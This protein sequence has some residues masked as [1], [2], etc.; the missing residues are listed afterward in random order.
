MVV[1]AR[2]EFEGSYSG[3]FLTVL[4]RDSEQGDTD[5]VRAACEDLPWPV[6]ETGVNRG[7][8]ADRRSDEPIGV[9]LPVFVGGRRAPITAD[10]LF[11]IN[12]TSPCH[13]ESITCQMTSVELRSVRGDEPDP[14]VTET[15]TE[16]FGE[17]CG[18]T[19]G[20]LGAGITLLA[21]W[22]RREA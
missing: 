20:I 5:E 4:G 3:Q 2:E 16:G 11:V 1:P 17:G 10:I 22:L 18:V 9:R 13:G 12:R 21:T 14:K 15:D 8:L 19:T 7:Q 6:D